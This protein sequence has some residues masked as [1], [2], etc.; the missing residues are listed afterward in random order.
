MHD[1]DDMIDIT[2]YDWEPVVASLVQ[3]MENKWADDCIFANRFDN[4]AWS[5]DLF[6]RSLV[7][8]QPAGE[9]SFFHFHRGCPATA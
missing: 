3:V 9:S 5:H 6:D 4:A 7:K 8:M 2:V 1:A